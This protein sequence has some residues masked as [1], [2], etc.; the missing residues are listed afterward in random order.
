MTD[1]ELKT[2]NLK[3]NETGTHVYLPWINLY[4][5]NWKIK[6]ISVNGFM[7]FIYRRGLEIGIEQGK[8]EKVQELK[9]LLQIEN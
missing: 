8:L 2:F 9:T 4:M 3:I 1:L 5:E 6:K 7:K